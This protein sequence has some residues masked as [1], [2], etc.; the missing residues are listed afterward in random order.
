VQTLIL[1][2]IVVGLAICT[3]SGYAL[4][5]GT[6]GNWLKTSAWYGRFQRWFAGSVYI[7]LG[8]MAAFSSSNAKK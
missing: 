4:L 3:D 5:A 7:G 6:L 1:G 8:L 2:L